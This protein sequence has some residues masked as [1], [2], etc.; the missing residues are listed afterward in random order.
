ML[1]GVE[2]TSPLRLLSLADATPSGFGTWG[3]G[4]SAACARVA[5]GCALTRMGSGAGFA[6]AGSL[7][8]ATFVAADGLTLADGFPGCG[9]TA[10]GAGAAC[11]VG[12][13][14]SDLAPVGTPDDVI[15]GAVV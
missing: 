8:T 5:D 4:S 11:V 12:V 10:T 7:A 6:T 1:T 9:V 15:G 3:A 2:A 13:A 14:A